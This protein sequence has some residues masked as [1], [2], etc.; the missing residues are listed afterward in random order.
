MLERIK[1]FF[2]PKPVQ[3]K[4]KKYLELGEAIVTINQADGTTHSVSVKGRYFYEDYE[5]GPYLSVV[6]AEEQVKRY[7]KESFQKGSFNIGGNEFLNSNLVTK[8]SY[9]LKPYQV[10]V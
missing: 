7:I 5:Y 4:E 1:K 2:E 3:P 10:E 9:E 6:R 8:V